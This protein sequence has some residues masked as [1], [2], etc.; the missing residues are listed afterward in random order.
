MS[1]HVKAYLVICIG[2][3]L[4]L[5]AC[6]H[7]HQRYTDA[8]PGDYGSFDSV[9]LVSCYD[10]DTCFFN[11]PNVHP[12]LGRRIGVRLRGVDTPEIRGKCDREKALAIKARDFVFKLL[13][14]SKIISIKKGVEIRL[15]NTDRDKYFRILAHITADGVNLSEILLKNDLAVSYKGGHKM[16]WC[17]K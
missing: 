14:N 15:E 1:K 8:N 4:S 12:L 6:T 11:I 2:L 16:N 5:S 7:A 3:C 9:E 13:S 17:E 10:G